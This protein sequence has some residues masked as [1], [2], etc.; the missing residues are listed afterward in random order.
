MYELCIW[1]VFVCV[2]FIGCVLLDIYVFV[3][4]VVDGGDVGVGMYEKW[5]EWV[6]VGVGEVDVCFVFVCDCYC[7][8]VDVILFGCESCV[9]L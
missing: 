6:D 3:V 2:G 1:G 5:L 4:E 9:G 7:G 8:G